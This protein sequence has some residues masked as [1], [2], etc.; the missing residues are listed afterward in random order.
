MSFKKV[1][2]TSTKIIPATLNPLIFS[3]QEGVFL[4]LKS[5]IEPQDHALL[6]M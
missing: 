4:S 2:S 3:P 6:C 5:V 1:Q